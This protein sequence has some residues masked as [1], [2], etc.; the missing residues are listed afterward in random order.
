MDQSEELVGSLWTNPDIWTYG[1]DSRSDSLM[2]G[3]F[4]D[5]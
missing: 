5:G 4:W 1:L 3:D 2:V